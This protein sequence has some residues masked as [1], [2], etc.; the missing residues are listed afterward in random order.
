MLVSP[1]QICGKVFE[2]QIF[3]SLFEYFEDNKFLSAQKCYFRTDDFCVNQPRS[4][5]CIA[6]DAYPEFRGAFQTYIQ[7]LRF[8]NLNQWGFPM[9]C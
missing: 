8:S 3:N 7:C 6:S 4:I 9:H 5:A 2:R 1:Q